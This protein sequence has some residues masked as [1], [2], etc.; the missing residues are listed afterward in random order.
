MPDRGDGDGFTTAEEYI[1][2]TDPTDPDSTFRAKIKIVDGKTVITYEPDLL[3]ERSYTTWGK[4]NLSAPTADWQ[5][6]EKG[7][8]SDYNFFKMTV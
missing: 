3:E 8:E 1:I 2:G 7:R 6:V 5:K 4:K